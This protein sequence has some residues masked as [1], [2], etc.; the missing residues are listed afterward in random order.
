MV[1]QQAQRQVRRVLV[2]T[3]A[4]VIA[5]VA[6]V[7]AEPASAGTWT[8]ISCRQPDGQPAPTEG[9]DTAAI[10]SPGFYTEGVNTCTQPGGSMVA[11]SSG[12]W[13]QPADTGYEWR[14]A[15]PKGSTIAGGQVDVGLSA[16]HGVAALLTAEQDFDPA[17][18][19]KSCGLSETCGI[20]GGSEWVPVTHTGGTG[21]Y[22]TAI[23]FPFGQG[24]G[25]TGGVD[26]EASVYAAQIELES[27]VSPAGSGFSGGL[28]APGASGIQDLVFTA[29]VPS[30]PGIWQ[31]TA[32][33]DGRTV[34]NVTPDTNSGKCQ[35]IGTDSAGAAEFLYEQPCKQSETVSIPVDTSQFETGAH[36]LTVVVTDA[37]GD[38]A[39]VF[40]GTINTFNASSE[41]P[42]KVSLR[43]SPRHVH[44][45]TGVRL[46]GRVSTS[47]LPAKGKIVWLQACEITFVKRVHVHHRYWVPVCHEWRT[48]KVLHTE[49]SGAYK[50]TYHFR[51]GGRHRYAFQTVAPHEGDFA[52]ATGFSAITE[53][54]ET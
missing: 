24:C 28:L 22:A 12:R 41:T 34:Y 39:A 4:A 11:V 17:Y 43:I 1:S 10:G 23:C 46:T 15:A 42:W 53:V 38:A 29:A 27:D 9:W 5:A 3:T 37:A 21:L 26:A 8:L 44:L 18:Q 30:G 25:E 35:S 16:P 49:P 40:D 31:V 32:A 36:R 6:L 33:I 2:G 19:L 7:G 51:F 47:P 54:T 52:A 20:S 48:F 14:F 13:V 45:H 50:W